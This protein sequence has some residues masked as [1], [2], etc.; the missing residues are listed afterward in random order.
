MSTP[1]RTWPEGFD[2]PEHV[3]ELLR[4]AAED[5]LERAWEHRGEWTEEIRARLLN[6]AR[7]VEVFDIGMLAPA[8]VAALADRA[9]DLVF[10]EEVP[11]PEE[12]EDLNAYVARFGVC[13]ELIVLRDAAIA[14]GEELHPPEVSA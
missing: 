2:V 1:D 8:Q 14:R 3:A 10:E 9:R 13:R 12:L 6:A 5:E 11:V 7:V 4:A